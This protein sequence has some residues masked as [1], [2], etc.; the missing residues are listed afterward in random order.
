MKIATVIARILLGLLFAV[1]GSN[2]FLQF[3]PMPKMSGP[4]GD[5]I[6]AMASTG[7]LQWVAA[8]QVLGGIILIIGRYV[9]LG[10]TL[11]GPIVVNIVLYHVC[12]DRTGT[13]IALVVA[14]LFAFLLW[15][16]RDAFAGVLRA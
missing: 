1:L 14:I 2:A 12:M 16:Y 15:R 7:Y 3:M 5:F 6:G 8:F 10:L 13:P 4:S 9:P 11:L